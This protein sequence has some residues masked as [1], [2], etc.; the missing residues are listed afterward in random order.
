MRRS[1]YLKKGLQDGIPICMGYFAV[2]F[3][4]GIFAKESGMTALQ[5]VVLSITNVTS[6]GQLAGIQLMSVGAGYS[7]VLCTQIVLNLRYALMSCSLSQKLDFN[8]PIRHRFLMAYGVSVC[9]EGKL[10]PYYSYG[11]II[12]SVTGWTMGTLLGVVAGEFLPSSISSALGIAIY[13]MF[14]AI[15]IPPAKTNK[16]VAGVVIS[17]MVGSLLFST[18]PLLKEI[19]FG[20]R[21]IIITVLTAG[22]AAFMFPITEDKKEEVSHAV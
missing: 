13:G 4:L 22:L 5:A 1:N 12:I 8:T 18:L 20:F 7:E 15:I 19:S 21:T 11:L 2:S 6:A 10:S 9:T 17:A 3:A 14:L 16:V